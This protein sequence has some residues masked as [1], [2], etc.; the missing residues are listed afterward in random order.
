MGPPFRGQNPYDTYPWYRK[1][2][3]LIVHR[4][5]RVPLIC[6]RRTF[7]FDRV[8]HD[9]YKGPAVDAI[10]V[11]CADYLPYDH[12]IG[13][14]IS[15]VTWMSATGPDGRTAIMERGRDRG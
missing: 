2:W 5:G 15:R 8:Q 4:S 9:C 13:E 1:G 3:W 10:V 11:E 7:G 14:V 6:R 12:Y